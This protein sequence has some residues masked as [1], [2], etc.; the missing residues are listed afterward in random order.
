MPAVTASV[1]FT[2]VL[3]VTADHIRPNIS[4]EIVQAVPFLAHLYR[5]K[6][7]RYVGSPIIRIPVVVNENDPNVSHL[8]KFDTFTTAPTDGPD[9]ARYDRDAYNGTVRSSFIIAKED[10]R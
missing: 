1:T 6:A 8:A 4:L 7:V 5:Q 9:T 3:S 10:Q 2:D